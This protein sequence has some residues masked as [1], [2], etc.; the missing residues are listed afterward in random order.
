LR[1]L[2]PSKFKYPLMLHYTSKWA[3]I[4]TTATSHIIWLFVWS[5]PFSRFKLILHISSWNNLWLAHY[6][7]NPILNLRWMVLPCVENKLVDFLIQ[8]LA[9]KLKSKWTFTCSLEHLDFFFFFILFYLLSSPKL[10]WSAIFFLS[11]KF[12]TVATV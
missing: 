10:S 6:M 2:S 8:N 11:W 4:L 9:V 5:F 7:W 12:T 1:R 3:H